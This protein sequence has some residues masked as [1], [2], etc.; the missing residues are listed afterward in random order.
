LKVHHKS[1]AFTKTHNRSVKQNE[2][3]QFLSSEANM[4]GNDTG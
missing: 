4:H 2:T 3:Q 1:S